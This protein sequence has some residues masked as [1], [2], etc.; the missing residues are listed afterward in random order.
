MSLY[1]V[2]KQ[3]MY[4]KTFMDKVKCKNA[5]QILFNFIVEQSKAAVAIYISV[6]LLE[7]FNLW[8]SSFLLKCVLLTTKIELDIIKDKEVLLSPIVFL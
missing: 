7:H 6:Y 5:L 8:L 2:Q 1:F 4:Y 3:I